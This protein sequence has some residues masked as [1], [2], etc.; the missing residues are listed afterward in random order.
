VLIALL[1]VSVA[2]DAIEHDI[3][4]SFVKDFVGVDDAV[5]KFVSSLI[6]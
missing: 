4:L 5:L 6:S 1:D 3:L 2:F